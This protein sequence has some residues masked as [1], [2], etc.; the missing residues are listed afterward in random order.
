MITIPMN[1]PSAELLRLGGTANATQGIELRRERQLPEGK[2]DAEH[3]ADR[4]AQREIFGKKV[5]EHPPD[6]ADRSARRHDEIEQP[7]HLVEDEQHCREQQRSDQRNRYG[8]C[9]VSI[10]QRQSAHGFC[11]PNTMIWPQTQP[12]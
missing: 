2:Q 3:Q 4:N 6:D 12:R 9:E 10:D 8:L 11:R 5:G 1:M 7:Q